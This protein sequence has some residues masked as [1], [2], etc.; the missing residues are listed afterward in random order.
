MMDRQ[1]SH[2]V[3]LV[4]DLLDVSR[5]SQGKIELRKARIALSDVFKTAIEASDT[6]LKKPGHKPAI[7]YLLQFTPRY[8]D[9]VWLVLWGT[10]AGAAR[11]YCR[12]PAP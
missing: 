9:P 11:S 7:S 4:D 6:Y 12:T 1:L 8:P 3:R 10:S 5:V 2:L